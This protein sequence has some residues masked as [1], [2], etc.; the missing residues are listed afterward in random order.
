M[1]L[2]LPIVPLA[3]C[4]FTNFHFQTIVFKPDIN[5]PALDNRFGF[6]VSMSA[7]GN[8]FVA[9]TPQFDPL[10]KGKLFVYKFDIPSNEYRPLPLQPAI[11]RTAPSPYQC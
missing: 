2:T 7:D 11:T 9:G 8:T 5:G 3:I 1:K 6:S 10:Q 4:K